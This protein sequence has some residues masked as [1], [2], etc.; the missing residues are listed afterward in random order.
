MNPCSV[1]P[2]GFK[3]SSKFPI[4]SSALIPSLL[5]AD[6]FHNRAPIRA[7]GGTSSSATSVQLWLP[8]IGFTSSEH[9]GGTLQVHQPSVSIARPTKPAAE[10]KKTAAC[11]RTTAKSSISELMQ[12]Y[13]NISLRPSKDCEPPP[14]SKHLSKSIQSFHERSGISVPVTLA[15]PVAKDCNSSH[16]SGLLDISVS[17][18]TPCPRHPGASLWYPGTTHICAALVVITFS[19]VDSSI[20]QLHQV[21]IKSNYRRVIIN[22]F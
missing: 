4:S 7:R 9:L 5:D 12:R 8:S 10:T 22:P 17:W 20:A 1:L 2:S 19:M 21:H 13:R 6:G 15:I 14:T 18:A 3:V 16:L 11:T